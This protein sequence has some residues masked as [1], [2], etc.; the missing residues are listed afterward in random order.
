MCYNLPHTPVFV[1]YSSTSQF[2]HVLL[3]FSLCYY[4]VCLPLP[5]CFKHG[6]TALILA[7][8]GGHTAIVEL[9]LG[10]GADK[11]AKNNLSGRETGSHEGH[12]TRSHRNCGAVVGSGG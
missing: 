11:E 2:P 7:S 1:A 5:L 4:G 3:F 8:E 6:E 12:D 10:A 9:L